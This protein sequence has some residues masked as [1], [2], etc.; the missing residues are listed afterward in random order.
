MRPGHPLRVRMRSD[1]QSGFT[2]IELLVV[3]LILGALAAIAIPAFLTQR[4]K[5]ND[6]DVKSQARTMQTAMETCSTENDAATSF[7]GCNLT[8][9]N[10][11]EPAI[12]SS[13]PDVTLIDSNRGFVVTSVAASG[14]GNSFQIRRTS[15]ATVTRDCGT[16]STGSP[17][18]LT[19][20]GTGGCPQNGAW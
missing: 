20:D 2:L 8:K 19:N 13:G 15:S 12:P 14:T 11:I 9:L 18:M 7:A 16:N 17:P 1:D 4:N 5:A 6:A 3:L 10:A